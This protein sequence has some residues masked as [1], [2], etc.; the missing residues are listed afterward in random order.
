MFLIGFSGELRIMI[1]MQRETKRMLGQSL[2]TIWLATFL[3]GC[4]SVQAADVVRLAF[5]SFSATN[6]GFLT[7]I[8]EKLFEKRGI[9]LVHVYI[10]SSSIVLIP[11]TSSSPARSSS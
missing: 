2:I 9:D 7:A 1:I 11:L 10:A 3:F 6:A 5:S 8:E 4:A